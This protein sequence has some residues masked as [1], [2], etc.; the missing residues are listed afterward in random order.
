MED[1]NRTA[2]F[3][4]RVTAYLAAHVNYPK[5][6]P[7][8][9][10]GKDSV[11]EEITAGAQY[12][13]LKREKVVGAFVL[14]E[15]PAG[16]YDAGDWQRSLPKGTYLVIHTFAV[17]PDACRQGIG[18]FM[19]EYCIKKAAEDGYSSLRLDVVPENLPARRLYESA[20]FMFAGEKDL[21]RGIP[22]IPR[23]ALY[24]RN[25]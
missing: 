24:E 17:A 1:L 5:W 14:S 10:P 3:Y 19:T 4:D 22:D 9:Y 21:G 12:I 13:C 7:G 6:V 15:D 11:C 16:N 8:S 18:R 25:L 23:F 20:G 2:A